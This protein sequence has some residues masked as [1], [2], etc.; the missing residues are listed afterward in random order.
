MR[1]EQPGERE[2]EQP[3]P[4][5]AAAADGRRQRADDQ[6]YVSDRAV[7]A[8]RPHGPVSLDELADDGL[9]PSSGLT[10]WF[11]ARRAPCDLDRCGQ[12]AVGFK[13]LADVVEVAD[14]GLAGLRVLQ[15]LGPGEGL[16]LGKAQFGGGFYE[17]SLRGKVPIHGTDADSGDP[18][19]LR[20]LHLVPPLGKQGTGG[21]QDP[22]PVAGGVGSRTARCR[23][24]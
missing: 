18:G 3:S 7:V 24:P 5:A 21:P 16:D 4:V 14:D 15:T 12:A 11:A 8:E 20:Q 13:E 17:V 19:Y 6:V 22:C 9:E 10:A 1:A 2:I 23:R